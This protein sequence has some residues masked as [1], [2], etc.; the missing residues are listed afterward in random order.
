MSILKYTNSSA[1][2]ILYR[3]TKKKLIKRVDHGVYCKIDSPLLRE[4]IKIQCACGCGMEFY[5]Y[6]K[7]RRERI[8]ISGHNFKK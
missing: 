7:H 2:T 5:K 4:N 6:D 8:Y 3:L 1:K